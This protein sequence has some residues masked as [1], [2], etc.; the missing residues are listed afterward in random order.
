[1]RYT[2]RGNAR[3]PPPLVCTCEGGSLRESRISECR[4]TLSRIREVTLDVVREKVFLP[5]P[6]PIAE[7][8]RRISI[9]Y[10]SYA[11][12]TLLLLLL[13]L[14]VLLFDMSRYSENSII[15]NISRSGNF[16]LH[17][18]SRIFQILRFYC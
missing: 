9:S 12:C 10:T 17:S 3:P 14:C 1:M 13:L 11:V 5:P 2:R 7:V 8:G 4:D 6:P 16:F 15:I 18:M